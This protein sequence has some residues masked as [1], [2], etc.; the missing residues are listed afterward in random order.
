[1]EKIAVFTSSR[2]TSSLAVSCSG[3]KL[4]HWAYP[5]LS[6]RIRLLQTRWLWRSSEER[7][8][9][10]GHWPYTSQWSTLPCIPGRHHGAVWAQT[11]RQYAPEC[12]GEASPKW[13]QCQDPERYW[14]RTEA[15][16]QHAGLLLDDE[17]NA[18]HSG[19]S[20]WGWVP[21]CD[22]SRK[23]WSLRQSPDTTGTGTNGYP[24]CDYTLAILRTR[25]FSVHC[26]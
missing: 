20:A 10:C 12:R 7:A 17:P 6:C 19:V 22:R 15:T 25:A 8:R 16:G 23:L 3:I 26:L 24:F 9:G 14:G 13:V 18:S 1:M 11:D 5:A 4:S 2:A 21:L